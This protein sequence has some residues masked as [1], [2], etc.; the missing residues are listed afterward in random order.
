VRYRHAGRLITDGTYDTAE[1]AQ[2]RV[3]RLHK[4]HSGEDAA[5]W[6]LL[7]ARGADPAVLDALQAEHAGIDP[8]LAA[9][10]AVLHTLAAGTRD[11][12]TRDRLAATTARLRDALGAHLADEERNG[13]A[14]VQRHLTQQDWDRLD[15]EV[16]AEDY[17]LRE[18]P[19]V[20][21]CY[22]VCTRAL[23]AAARCQPR[24]PHLRPA[25]GPAVRPA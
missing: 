11:A 4:H 6:P 15:R 10:R 5:L 12:A 9:T 25:D 24:F 3:Q 22:P 1:A 14:L 2:A 18:V 20:L 16:F 17:R 7:A 8:Q 21:G 13:M 23:A 19:E